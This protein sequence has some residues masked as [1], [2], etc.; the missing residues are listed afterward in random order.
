MYGWHTGRVHH[1]LSQLEEF[2]FY[3]LEWRRDVLDIRE[4]FPL[5]PLHETVQIAELLRVDHP[6]DK[7]GNLVVMTE[8]FL[9]TCSAGGIIKARSIKPAPELQSSRVW[10][11]LRIAQGC[12]AA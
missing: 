8:D 12:L 11:K 5:L 1:F 6:R 2:Y 7:K 4:Q 9:I 10:E 3:T